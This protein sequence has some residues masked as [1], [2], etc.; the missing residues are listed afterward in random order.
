MGCGSSSQANG[1]SEEDIR[2]NKEIEKG[3]S[4]DRAALKVS[5]KQIICSG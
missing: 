3:L 1:S 2:R 5:S 4:A